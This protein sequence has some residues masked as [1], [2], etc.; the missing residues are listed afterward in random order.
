LRPW[1]GGPTAAFHREI[2]FPEVF[3]GFVDLDP[4]HLRPKDKIKPGSAGFDVVIGNPPYDVLAE[5]EIEADLED[6]LAHPGD[7]DERPGR[8]AAGRP[9]GAARLPVLHSCFLCNGGRS[10]CGRA[11]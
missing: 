7:G 9:G 1:P 5:K 11:S 4:R 8:C 10:V 6:I 3:C 2:E